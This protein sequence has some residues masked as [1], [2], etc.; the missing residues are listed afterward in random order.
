MRNRTNF[1]N[2]VELARTQWEFGT[3]RSVARRSTAE[4][5]GTGRDRRGVDG[6]RSWGED[7]R[8][9]GAQRTR[10]SGGSRGAAATPPEFVNTFVDGPPKPD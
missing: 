4:R 5:A 7:S 8:R 1:P 3:A 6:E 2:T 9:A 10:L